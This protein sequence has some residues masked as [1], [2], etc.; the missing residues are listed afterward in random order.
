LLLAVFIH[1]DPKAIQARDPQRDVAKAGQLRGFGDKSGDADHL[2]IL[3][4]LQDALMR[5]SGFTAAAANVVRVD[6]VNVVQEFNQGHVNVGHGIQT[7]NCAKGIRVPI[8][9][10]VY[11]GAQGATPDERRSWLG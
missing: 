5:E 3:Q 11:L 4:D 9:P 7:A 2:S 10:D 1:A 8:L 6:L